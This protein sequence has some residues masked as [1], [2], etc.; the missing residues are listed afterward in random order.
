MTKI[1]CLLSRESFDSSVIALALAKQQATN[2][3]IS[4][5]RLLGAN[6]FVKRFMFRWLVVNTV[7]Y[8]WPVELSSGCEFGRFA[9]GCSG[10][11]RVTYAK[12][13]LWW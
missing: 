7:K 11:P 4:N 3:G 5:E 1:E 8:P 12:N 10:C 9:A 13:R 2:T 6:D